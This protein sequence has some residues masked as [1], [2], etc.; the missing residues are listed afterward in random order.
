LQ[1]WY[2]GANTDRVVVPHRKDNLASC[3]QERSAWRF[4]QRHGHRLRRLRCNATAGPKSSGLAIGSSLCCA[5]SP[6]IRAK[7]ISLTYVQSTAVLERVVYRHDQRK[8]SNAAVITCC[9]C[10]A[11]KIRALSL[12]RKSYVDLRSLP[13][14]QYLVRARL[15]T[16]TVRNPSSRVHLLVLREA[17]R[18][19]D[20]LSDRIAHGERQRSRTRIKIRFRH[21]NCRVSRLYRVWRGTGGH[22]PNR[23]PPVCC[24]Q[25]VNA[26]ENVEPELLRR[27][28]SS[29][30]SENE[31][32]RLSR[33]K[34]NWI[35]EVQ[36]EAISWAIGLTISDPGEV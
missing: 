6:A 33:R 17:W 9:A 14:R 7:V 31:Q 25:R 11:R 30:E 36:F 1:C 13:L 5:Q 12:L 22:Q 8:I 23:R 29:F 16:G 32:A 24:R 19:L 21:Q 2:P 28:P 18:C 3:N 10:H 35:A 27:A 34:R 15:A 26:F 4:W 20:L